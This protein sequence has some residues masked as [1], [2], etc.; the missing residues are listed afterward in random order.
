M[1]RTH[2]IGFDVREKQGSI[3]TL[4]QSD[5][6][7]YLGM[8]TI[9]ETFQRTLTHFRSYLNALHREIST[10]ETQ[11]QSNFLVGQSFLSSYS[12]S[13]LFSLQ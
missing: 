10:E 1:C 13:S 7:E 11:E 12:L 3:F 8:I 5:Q 9:S 4:F 2:G 6:H